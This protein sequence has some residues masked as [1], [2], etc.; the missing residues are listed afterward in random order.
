MKL[1]TNTNSLEKPV[2]LPVVKLLQILIILL[3]LI[4]TIII[5]GL[6]TR[7]E[8]KIIEV[9]TNTSEQEDFKKAMD[10]YV[11]RV[12]LE[13]QNRYLEIKAALMTE[14]LERV[15]RENVINSLTPMELYVNYTYEISDK[16]YPEISPA[17]VCAIIYHE[18]RFD[19]SVTNTKTGV[20]GLCQINPKWH[21]NRANSLGVSDLYDPYGNILVCFD[22]LNELSL[23]GGL[24]YALNFYAGGYPYANRYLNETSPFERQ[25]A[26]IM[27]EQNFAQYVLP[28]P[29]H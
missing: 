2:G 24:S 28:Y 12:K 16:Y 8:E 13:E 5:F 4:C 14:E 7:P 1:T 11:Q 26:Q 23:S 3:G 25:L 10:A 27:D 18:S 20:Q 19:P 17:Y 6:L 29:V 15:N 22:I 9:P 21:T